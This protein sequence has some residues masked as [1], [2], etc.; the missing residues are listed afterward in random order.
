MKVP[1][2]GGN[3]GYTRNGKETHRTLVIIHEQFSGVEEQSHTRE[4]EAG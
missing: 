1:E 3:V 2:S 4:E